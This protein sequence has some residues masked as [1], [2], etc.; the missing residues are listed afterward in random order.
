V[1]AGDRIAQ[2]R[3]VAG[4]LEQAFVTAAREAEAERSAQS[5]PARKTS[6]QETSR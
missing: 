4:D 5:A 6:A 2:F 1:T 3:E